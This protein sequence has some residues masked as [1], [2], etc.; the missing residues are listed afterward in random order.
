MSQLYQ[1]H[2]R[3][4][5]DKFDTRRLADRVEEVIVHDVITDEDKQFIEARDMFFLSTVNQEGDP[6]VSYK[7]GDPGFVKVVDEK[8]IATATACSC[9]WET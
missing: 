3:Q 4:L 8:T 7:G 5:Q 2:H 6:T 9:P 1:D